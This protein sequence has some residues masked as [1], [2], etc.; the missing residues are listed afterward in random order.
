MPTYHEIMTT[1]LSALTAAADRWDGMAAEFGKR[2]AHYGRAVHGVSMGQS[3]Q[4]L[5]ADAANARFDITLEQFRAA[6]TEARALASLLR[7]AHTQFVDLRGAVRAVRQAAFDAGMRV[8]ERGVVSHDADRQGGKGKATATDAASWQQRL[9][10]AVR[11]VGD[12]DQGAELALAAVVVDADVCDGTLNGFNSRALG[13]IEKYEARA[14]DEI[15]MRLSGGADLPGSDI[16]ELRRV[17]RDNG[18]DKAF[19]RTFLDGLGA[20]GTIRMTNRLND[21]IHARGGK[22]SG[23]FSAIESGLARTLATA[24][25]DTRSGWYKG[26]RAD[27]R[28]AGGERIRTAFHDGRLDKVRG[29]QSLVTLMGKGHGYAPQFLEDVSDDIIAAERKNPDVWD[30]K[31]PY[32]GRRG[33]WFANDPLDGV[34][35]VMSHDPDTAAAYLKSDDRMKYLMEE[36]DWKVVVQER[37]GTKVST[38]S[39]ALDADDRAGFGAALQAAATGIDPSDRHGVFV[40]HSKDNDAVFRSSLKYLA[41]NGDDFPASLREPVARILVNHGDTVHA[42][43]SSVDMSDSPVPQDRL[44]EVM[45]QVSK[46]Q[47]AYGELNGGLNRTMVAEIHEPG[48][49]N[50][51]DSLIRAGRTVGFLEGSRAQALGDPDTAAWDDKWIFDRAISYLPVGSDDVQQGFDYV[52]DKWLADEQQRLDERAEDRSI[53][54]YRRR[55]GQL[56]AIAGEWQK[57]HPGSGGFA[58]QTTIERASNDGLARSTGVSGQGAS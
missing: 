26:W 50:P 33:G 10:R 3:W 29:Y 55:N 14:A 4:G 40:P 46:D 9:D 1:D 42:A 58:A 31:G 32:S 12:A 35:G 30:M 17:F 24:T 28:K 13:D 56:M 54:I 23:D 16:A 57:A 2:E 8:S 51:E 53:S 38:Y 44:F 5:S 22:R 25:R 43:A 45:K 39:D 6:Q 49:R 15:A 36:R 11:A 19:S 47:H 52:T 21:L 34:L 48:Q 27:M 37:D 20:G 18:D 7:D 41:A